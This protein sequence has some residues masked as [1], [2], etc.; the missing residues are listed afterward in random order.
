MYSTCLFNSNQ[1]FW[2][3]Y[4]TV[5]PHGFPGSINVIT[6]YQT[7]FLAGFFPEL[8]SFTPQ[9]HTTEKPEADADKCPGNMTEELPVGEV[10]VQVDLAGVMNATLPEG[11]HPFQYLRKDGELCSFYVIVKGK[12]DQ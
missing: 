12:W 3:I 1:K 10:V 6:E 8:A 4:Y 2:V 9:G 5:C 7:Q 11:Q